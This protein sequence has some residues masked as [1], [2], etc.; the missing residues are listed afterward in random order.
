MTGWAEAR[1]SSAA[2][3]IMAGAPFVL[4][5]DPGRSR[6]SGQYHSMAELGFL[7]STMSLGM[8]TRTGPGRPV[9][10]MWNASR[11]ALGMSWAEVTSR[12]CLVMPMVMPVMSAS[13]NASVPRADVGTWPVITTIGTESM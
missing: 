5:W 13:W 11:I 9:V 4:G 1:I 8:S 6:V 7:G 2:L 12:L 3:R 10:A